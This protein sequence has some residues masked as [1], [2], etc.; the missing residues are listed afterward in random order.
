MGNKKGAKM[1]GQENPKLTKTVTFVIRGWFESIFFWPSVVTVEVTAE[2]KS[3]NED[4]FGFAALAEIVIKEK[5]KIVLQDEVP[6]P[7]PIGEPTL[8]LQVYFLSQ[9]PNYKHPRWQKVMEKFCY[10][11]PDFSPPNK[12][13]W[14][15]QD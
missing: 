10:S 11:F 12:I 5:E 15:R 8:L 7:M 1:N 13:Y 6:W 3:L 9:M 4:L 2:Q 14:G